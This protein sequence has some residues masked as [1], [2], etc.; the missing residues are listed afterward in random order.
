[1]PQIQYNILTSCSKNL[2]KGGVMVYSTCTLN[3]AENGEN[4]DRFLREHKD[5]EPL[6]IFKDIE[7][8][9]DEPENQ[10]TLFTGKHPCDGFFIS[11]FKKVR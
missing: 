10:M 6:A 3:P 9:I 1:M 7:R 2:K 5:F 8:S 4:A 11:A